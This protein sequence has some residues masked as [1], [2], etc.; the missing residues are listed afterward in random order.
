MKTLILILSL[1]CA[2]AQ[3]DSTV[4]VTLTTADEVR[5]DHRLT[6]VNKVRSAQGKKD[7]TRDDYV[8][9]FGISGLVDA[10]K[11]QLCVNE[12]NQELLKSYRTADAAKKKAIEDAAK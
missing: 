7:W 9:H 3:A 8:T 10:S 11:C 4:F 6:H 1:I 2:T 12:K 5:I